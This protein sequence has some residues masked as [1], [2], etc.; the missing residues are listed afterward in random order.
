MRADFAFAHF[1]RIAAGWEVGNP[2][3]VFA[4]QP[5]IKAIFVGEHKIE[6]GLANDDGEQFIIQGDTNKI[7]DL[8]YGP[9]QI[10]SHRLVAK[11]QHL[12]FGA[13]FPP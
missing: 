7:G 5:I 2:F 10:L 4:H 13:H 1:G 9:R 12:R 8:V 11:Q 6:R 3:A